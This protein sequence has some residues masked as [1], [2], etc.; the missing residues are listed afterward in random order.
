MFLL[1]WFFG[2]YVERGGAGRRPG[3]R[4]GARA[5]RP[6]HAAAVEWGPRLKDRKQYKFVFLILKK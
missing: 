3:H 5:P 4:P 6:V 2:V 1:L